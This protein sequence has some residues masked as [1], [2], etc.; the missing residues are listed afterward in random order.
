[1]YSFILIIS[2]LK[3][4][5]FYTAIHLMYKM[6]LS[7]PFNTFVE[8][9]ICTYPSSLTL[10]KDFAQFWSIETKYKI[11]QQTSYKI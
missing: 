5:L 6:D 8:K 9:Q 7:K 1:V 4:I 3:A 11:D 10:D 2:I